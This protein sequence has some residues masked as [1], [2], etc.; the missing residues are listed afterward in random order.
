MSETATTNGGAA[1][2]DP[3]LDRPVLSDLPVEHLLDLS[4]DL[5]PV[6]MIPT[7][8]G[9]RMVYIAR[10][11]R[12]DGPR[13][14]GELLPGGGDWLHVGD[15]LIGRVD[16]R[17]ML[18]TDDGALIHYTAGGVI[19]VPPDG[20]TRLQAGERLSFEETYVRTTPKFETADERY[21]WLNELVVVGH[22]ELSKDH[23]DY[24]MYRVL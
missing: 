23:I 17:A 2:A 13:L 14:K 12:F 11:G 7:P 6:R 19:R 9:A 21:S 4:V 3:L 8:V 20:L 24:R 10:G 1:L 22:N 15:D 16:V 18:Q 5:E